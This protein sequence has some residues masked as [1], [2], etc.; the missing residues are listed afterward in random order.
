LEKIFSEEIEKAR[1]KKPA[2]ARSR[3]KAGKSKVRE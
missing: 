1:R 2:A 3:K